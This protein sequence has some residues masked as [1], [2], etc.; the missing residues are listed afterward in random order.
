MA[1]IS[2]DEIQKYVDSR[3]NW[4]EE[5]ESPAKECLVINFNKGKDNIVIDEEMVNKT[6]Y[7]QSRNGNVVVYFD[8]TGQ[9]ISIEIV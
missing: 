8:N 5:G 4:L 3:K 6:L 2:I 1:Y 9:I 7:L